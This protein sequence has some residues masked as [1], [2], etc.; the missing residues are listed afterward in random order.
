M[1]QT[2]SENEK[3]WKLH[4]HVFYHLFHNNS[5]H[6]RTIDVDGNFNVLLPVVL[7]LAGVH[8]ARR[9][10]RIQHDSM[11]TGALYYQEIM[12][13]DNANRFQQLARMD[14]DAFNLLK[15]NLIEI[16]LS[17]LFYRLLNHPP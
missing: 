7:G 6:I 4:C 14:K 8:N 3:K 1:R 17:F 13:T 10:P 11:L 15:A 12:N 5:Q 2:E 9:Q 16:H